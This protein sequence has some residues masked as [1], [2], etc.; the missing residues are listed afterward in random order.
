M[1]RTPELKKPTG[2]LIEHTDQ[3]TGW[4]YQLVDGR[5]YWTQNITDLP[6]GAINIR[7]VENKFNDP[8]KKQVY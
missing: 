7:A 6:K 5:F 4:I 8:V 1:A 2:Q 3:T